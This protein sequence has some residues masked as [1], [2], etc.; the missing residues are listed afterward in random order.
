M[1]KVDKL[2]SELKEAAYKYY[3]SNEIIMSDEDY[4]NKLEY[5]SELV[6]EDSSLLDNED[7]YNL[8]SGSVSGG[9]KPDS[10]VGVVSH[11]LQMGSLHKAKNNKELKLFINRLEE[12]GVKSVKLQSKLD[13]L[14]LEGKY[15]SGELVQVS[16]RGD[17]Y[18]GQDVS[19]LIG[20]PELTIIGLPSRLNKD[21]SVSIRGELFIR[22]S[23][24]EVVEENRVHAGESKPFSL[25]RMAAVGMLSK[26]RDGLGYS[27]ELTFCTYS[28]INEDNE[29]L[30]LEKTIPQLDGLIDIN[31]LSLSEY[32]EA[33]GDGTLNSKC[34]YPEVSKLIESFGKLRPIFDIP[35]DGAVIKPLDEIT[36]FNEMGSTSKAPNAYIAY[37]YPEATENTKVIDIVY[38][39][40]K[41]GKI[42]PKA[43]VETVLVDG[44]NIDNIVLHNFNWIDEKDVRIGS[45][46][47]VHKA[48]GIIPAI[49]TVI[50]V[51]DGEKVEPLKYCPTCGSELVGDGLDYPK[52]LDCKNEEC[53]SRNYFKMRGIVSKEGL[54]IDG[55][56][57][58]SLEALCATGEVNS[59]IDIFNLSEDTLANLVIGL[60]SSGNDKLLGNV[61]ASKII[62]RI[63]FAKVNTPAHK[64]LNTLGYLGIGANTCKTLLDNFGSIEAVVNANK[65]DL[66]KIE[67]FGEGKVESLMSNQENARLQV[68]ELIEMNVVMDNGIN[69]VVNDEGKVFAISGSVPSNF[70]NRGEFTDYMESI[71]HKFSSSVNKKVDV[72]FGDKDDTSSKIVKAKKLGIEIISPSEYKNI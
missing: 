29:Y 16:T 44:S 22:H 37:K 10:E 52:T 55:L 50:E 2:V 63:N 53:A 62:S 17:G 1:N 46:V 33:G 25:P 45:T 43:I 40:G 3:Q 8:V 47:A 61:R 15:I 4:D 60:T 39:T 19:Y 20:H 32:K 38:S 26:A 66:F 24:L 13:G 27:G 6:S 51:G 21:V 64:L 58:V 41:T 65:D 54:D 70:K 28:V 57:N 36:Y 5:L 71:G 34:T 11:S 35:T 69:K 67:G 9:T 30:Y 42:T 12:S 31:N 7:I 18:I 14:A 56:N 23:Q 59:V 68:S 48:N 72:V 49:A